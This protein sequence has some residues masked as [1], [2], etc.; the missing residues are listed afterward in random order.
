MRSHQQEKHEGADPDFEMKVERMYKDLYQGKQ[1]KL[2]S[3]GEQMAMFSTAK[4]SST[5]PNYT[6][7][8]EKL[9]TAENLAQKPEVFKKVDDLNPSFHYLILLKHQPVLPDEAISR[10][11][12]LL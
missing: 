4:L 7:W 3:L 9:W 11:K 10:V 6:T 8:E 2:S 5:S 1:A 12:T